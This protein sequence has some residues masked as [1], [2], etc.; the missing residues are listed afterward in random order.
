MVGSSERDGIL[1]ALIENAIHFA[2]QGDLAQALG[3]VAGLSESEQARWG[4][5]VLAAVPAKK[6]LALPDL[7]GNA[8]LAA[9]TKAV[10]G[11]E[12]RHPA[13]GS[14]ATTS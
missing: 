13:P 12:A 9:A 14:T 3:I 2:Q 1:G 5:I 4:P 7:Y 11:A 6:G 8:A 10:E